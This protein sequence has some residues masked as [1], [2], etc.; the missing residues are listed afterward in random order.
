MGRQHPEY[1]DGFRYVD[2]DGRTYRPDGKWSCESPRAGY[3]L[4]R[5][6]S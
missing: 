1:S 6:I 4:I 3:D 5:L 2:T